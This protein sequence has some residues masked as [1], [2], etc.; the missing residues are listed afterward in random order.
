MSLFPSLVALMVVMMLALSSARLSQDAAMS[1]AQRMDRQLARHRGE[2]AL[3]R[4]AA[5]LAAG[6]PSGSDVSSEEVPI[7]GQAELGDLPLVL[8]RVTAIGAGQQVNVRVQADFAIDGCDSADDDPCS[9]RVRL[10]A[11]RELPL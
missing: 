5:A 9:P 6:E 3:R 8:H 2:L 11:W 10:I 1:A 7:S 4:A